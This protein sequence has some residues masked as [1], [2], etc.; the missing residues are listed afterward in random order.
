M[1][2]A[3]DGLG[4]PRVVGTLGQ[5][6]SARGVVLYHTMPSYHDTRASTSPLLHAMIAD[7]KLALHAMF[8]QFGPLLDIVASDAYRLRGQA[9]LVFEDAA[10]AAAAMRDMQSFPFYNKPLV[11]VAA[12]RGSSNRASG[13]R[14]GPEQLDLSAQFHD[15]L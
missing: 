13:G 6:S 14:G 7:L 5:K 9:W 4:V 10:H 2:D 11:R 15:S 12:G 1:R 3:I 8:D